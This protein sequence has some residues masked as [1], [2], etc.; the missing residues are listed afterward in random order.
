MMTRQDYTII[1][2]AFHDA[3][4]D[5]QRA[6]RYPQGEGILDAAVVLSR[7]LLIDNPRFDRVQFLIACGMPMHARVLDAIRN[8]KEGAPTRMYLK[9]EKT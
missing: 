2:S 3:L 1:S 4:D 7:R 6:G 9:R 8:D 5:H